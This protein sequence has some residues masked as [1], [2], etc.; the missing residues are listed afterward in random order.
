MKVCAAASPGCFLSLQTAAREAGAVVSVDEEIGAVPVAVEDPGVSVELDCPPAL[1]VGA[2]PGAEDALFE[3]GEL[4]S[5]AT[6][7]PG[8]W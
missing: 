5:L 8:Y 1:L 2:V 4:I 6:G 3:S 7:P